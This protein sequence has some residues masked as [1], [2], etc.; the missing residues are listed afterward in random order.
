[1]LNDRPLLNGKPTA[2][3]CQGFVCLQP[4]NL[5]SE[6]EIQLAGK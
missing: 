4:V 5:P 3:V 1:L 2:Y 6:M